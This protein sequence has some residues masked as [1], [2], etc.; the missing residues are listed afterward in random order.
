MAEVKSKVPRA[1]VRLAQAYI[2]VFSSRQG[3][4]VLADMCKNHG[5]FDYHPVSAQEMALKEG[6]RAVVLKIIKTMKLDL[7]Q[8]LER[9]EDYEKDMG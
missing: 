8:L 9:V 1:R 6:E 5:V 4:I 2:D 7:K 3:Q